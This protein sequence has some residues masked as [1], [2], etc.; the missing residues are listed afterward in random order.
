MYIYLREPTSLS[1]ELC[2]FYFIMGQMP[3]WNCLI[4][5]CSFFA[6]Q[7]DTYKAKLT[8]DYYRGHGVRGLGGCFSNRR[9]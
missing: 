2:V 1:R 5:A 4:W 6:S 8:N 3:I 9:C 7:Y